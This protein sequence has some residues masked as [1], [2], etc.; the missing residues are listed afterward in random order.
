MDKRFAGMLRELMT[1]IDDYFAELEAKGLIP[2]A[3]REKK[4]TLSRRA[5]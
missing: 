4:W 3:P 5:G 1:D 2:L